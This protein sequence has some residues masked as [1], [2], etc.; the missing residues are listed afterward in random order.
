MKAELFPTDLA[1][2]KLI[3]HAAQNME[4]SKDL[5]SISEL[6]GKKINCFQPF[7]CPYVVSC[8]LINLFKRTELALTSTRSKT[9]CFSW[10]PKKAKCT[11]TRH[12]TRINCSPYLTLITCRSMR[13]SGT[14]FPSAF[15]LPARAI[16]PWKSG[17]TD[18][19]RFR[20]LDIYL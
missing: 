20:L 16:G 10:E 8:C 13:S 15:S 17:I 5:A 3:D 12:F 14:R 1:Y 18:T 7:K 4:E 19:S 2:L 6:I 11:N 9:T